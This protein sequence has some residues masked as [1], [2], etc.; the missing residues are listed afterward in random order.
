MNT[1]FAA[2]ASGREL[3]LEHDRLLN[4]QPESSDTTDVVAEKGALP[5]VAQP[6]SNQCYSWL[7]VRR[8]CLLRN[9]SISFFLFGLFNNGQ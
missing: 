8:N 4:E 1:A 6:I 7:T 2:S 3:D 9:L 5:P